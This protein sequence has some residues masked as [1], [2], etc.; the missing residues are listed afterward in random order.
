[1]Q[2][3]T[4][5]WALAQQSPRALVHNSQHCGLASLHWEVAP[6][7]PN[8]EVLGWGLYDNPEATEGRVNLLPEW[9]TIF[10]WDRVNQRKSQNKP[11]NKIRKVGILSD[12]RPSPANAVGSGIRRGDPR[13]VRLIPGAVSAAHSTGES[14]AWEGLA[15]YE[16]PVFLNS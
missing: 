7:C 1:M 13:E 3:K 5:F 2:R 12:A 15:F 4:L 9:V 10:Q 16:L 6:K 8:R 11:R 14:S